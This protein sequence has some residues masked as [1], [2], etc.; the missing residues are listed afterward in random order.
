ML[1]ISE[2][3]LRDRYIFI[4]QSLEILNVFITLT[5]IQFF[6]KSKSLTLTTGALLFSWKHYNEKRH[7]SLKTVAS[8]ANVKTNRMGSTKWTYHNQRSFASNYF[9]FEN[10]I[11]VKESLISSWFNPR[12][13]QMS[14]FILVNVNAWVSPVS[15]LNKVVLYQQI[16]II[17]DERKQPPQIFLPKSCSLAAVQILQNNCEGVQI[18]TKLLGTLIKMS[19]YIDITL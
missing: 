18:L 5:L 14:I 13:T 17:F 19:S 2:I 10:L 7:I 3:A 8:K 15:I 9:F 6:W 16:T 11:S 4:W 12:T 1:E